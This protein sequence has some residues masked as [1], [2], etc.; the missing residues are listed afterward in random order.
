MCSGE[1]G[2]VE[3]RCVP[4]G[5]KKKVLL[6]D[7]QIRLQPATFRALDGESSRIGKPLGPYCSPFLLP[8]QDYVALQAFHVVCLE[9]SQGPLKRLTS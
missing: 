9:E 2:F 3:P 6:T 5:G 7:L 4:R 1:C 8:I